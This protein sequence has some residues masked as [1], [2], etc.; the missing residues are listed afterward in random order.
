MPNLSCLA[1]AG[2]NN[3]PDVSPYPSLYP[4]TIPFKMNGFIEHSIRCLMVWGVRCGMTNAPKR[5]LSFVLLIPPS[6]FLLF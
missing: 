2:G 5:S 1:M 6:L 4:S 3:Q